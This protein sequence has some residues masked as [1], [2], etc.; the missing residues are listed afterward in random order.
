M[1]E[2]KRWIE[3]AEKDFDVAKYNLDGKK[4]ESGI[5]F[6]QQ[7]AEKALKALYIKIFRDILKTHDLVLLAKKL[8]AP[9][10]I[11]DYCK[12]LTPAYQYTR[13]PDVPKIGKIDNKKM[14]NYCEEILIW[15]K[16]SI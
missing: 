7:S 15:V 5:F 11:L 8:N 10:E 3:Q 14:L 12:E 16:K 4:I 2:I 6:L 13:Y 1:E 9:N